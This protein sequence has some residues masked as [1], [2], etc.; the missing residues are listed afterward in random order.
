MELAKP[1]LAN[2]RMKLME[3]IWERIGSSNI[4]W[5][6]LIWWL[7]R[8]PREPGKTRTDSEQRIED[9]EERVQQLE[10]IAQ[11]GRI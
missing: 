6:A 10:Q 11:T 7:V 5:V 9:L 8:K 4:G 1:V 3:A 2:Y